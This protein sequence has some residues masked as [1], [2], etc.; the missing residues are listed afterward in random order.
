MCGMKAFGLGGLLLVIVFSAA[1]QPDCEPLPYSPGTHISGEEEPYS[2]PDVVA[3]RILFRLL[4]DGP[5]RAA[6][7]IR[8]RHLE[9]GGLSKDVIAKVMR[10][11]S[12][13]M[14]R[15][16][17]MEDEVEELQ[18]PLEETAEMLR[19]RRDA[20]V[21][22]AVRD[23]LI[24]E[25]DVVAGQELLD[26]LNGQ[27]KPAISIT[28]GSSTGGTRATAVFTT[29]SDH[30][31]HATAITDGDY[32]MGGV[33]GSIAVAKIV[34]P[35]GRTVESKKIHWSAAVADVSLP[36]EFE[37]GTFRAFNW[38]AGVVCPAC[39]PAVQK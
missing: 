28:V 31:V 15:V 9:E 6:A 10:T 34:S 35:A 22:V 30:A 8:A 19:E 14:Q 7:E 29:E 21:E 11:A 26:Y 4:A 13:A 18:L 38:R 2:I 39:K 1:A 27:V 12:Q 20:I 25:L 23:L 36:L 3:W 17:E 32:A 24:E 37:D 33:C 5:D 16:V